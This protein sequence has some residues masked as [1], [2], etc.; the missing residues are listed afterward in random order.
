MCR[1]SAVATITVLIFAAALAHTFTAPVASSMLIGTKRNQ[2]LGTWSVQ[3]LHIAL[4]SN[5]K[6]FGPE[7]LA[8][9]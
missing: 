6:R 5:I 9:P 1:I 2:T 4:P 8:F 3:G 7:M